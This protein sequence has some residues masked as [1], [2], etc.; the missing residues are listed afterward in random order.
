MADAEARQELRRLVESAAGRLLDAGL[1]WDEVVAVIRGRLGP[2]DPEPPEQLFGVPVG[3]QLRLRDGQVWR[4]DPDGPGG[5]TRGTLLPAEAGR[6]EPAPVWRAEVDEAVEK[7]VVGEDAEQ[8]LFRAA[9]GLPDDGRPYW[10]LPGG[11]WTPLSPDERYARDVDPTAPPHDLAPLLPAEDFLRGAAGVDEPGEPPVGSVVT[12]TRT[13]VCWRDEDGWHRAGTEQ[14]LTWRD[15]CQAVGGAAD[16]TPRPGQPTIVS[17]PP[18][19][20]QGPT[21]VRPAGSLELPMQVPV[22]D[23]DGQALL[24]P[25]G[26]PLMRTE[27]ETVTFA[28]VVPAGGQP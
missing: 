4:R 27:T 20:A 9:L 3:G 15:V 13:R 19:R 25:N 16:P 18:Q 28:E 5:A 11:G 17:Q 1:S 10:P 6:P 12:D 22:L 26:Q 21:V 24:G 8:R 23:G 14:A 7:L 2:V